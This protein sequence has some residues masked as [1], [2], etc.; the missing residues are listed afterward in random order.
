MMTR[1]SHAAS[2]SASRCA[3][4]THSIRP[5]VGLLIIAATAAAGCEALNPRPPVEAFANKLAEEAVIPAVR[6]GLAR[7]AQQLALQASAQ[8]INPT[9][10]MRFR[11]VWI[12]GLEGEASVGIDGIAGQIQISTSTSTSTSP[13]TA[14]EQPGAAAPSGEKP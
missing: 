3:Q 10:V 14:G 8:G 6:E 5:L 9:Y 13:A 1:T 4:A 12:T 11:G 7:G 2:P